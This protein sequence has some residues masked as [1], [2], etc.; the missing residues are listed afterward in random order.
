[1]KVAP[2]FGCL[3]QAR[4][5]KTLVK[6]RL[7]NMFVLAALV[8]GGWQLAAEEAAVRTAPAEVTLTVEPGH[9]WTP[10]F[11]V[12]RVGRPMEAVVEVPGG[13]KSQGRICGGRLSRKQRG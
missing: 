10:P 5:M 13:G 11:G 3:S 4:N 8:L 9:P 6:N 2:A 7:R 12:E 1:M